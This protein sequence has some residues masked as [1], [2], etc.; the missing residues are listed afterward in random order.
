MSRHGHGYGYGR[1][2]DAGRLTVADM[3]H[4][5]A[6]EAGKRDP[7]GNVLELLPSDRASYHKAG[8]NRLDYYRLDG[9]RAF[10]LIHT[11]IVTRLT[12][13]RILL[14]TGGWSSM[15]TR[16]GFLEGLERLCGR[17]AVNWSET[18]RWHV[19][20]VWGGG[21]RGEY[22]NTLVLGRCRKGEGPNGE[23]FE[24]MAIPFDGWISWRP[25]KDGAVN[26]ATLKRDSRVK[27][28]ENA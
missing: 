2:G 11:D 24:R 22:E 9:R 19:V 3:R 27:I 8:H 14:Q 17:R 7:L 6:V 10:R 23:K 4:S 21:K 1:A 26:L 12:D 15:T 20:N 13:G 25:Y 5:A 18:E 28:K 16:R